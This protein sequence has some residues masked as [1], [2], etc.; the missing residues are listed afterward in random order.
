MTSLSKLYKVNYYIAITGSAS[1]QDTHLLGKFGG[2]GNALKAGPRKQPGPATGSGLLSRT[3]FSQS[4]FPAIFH[5]AALLS[6]CPRH[7]NKI[8]GHD[9]LMGNGD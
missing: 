3:C 5:S 8:T 1:L 7:S 9:G 2:T 6:N 4:S